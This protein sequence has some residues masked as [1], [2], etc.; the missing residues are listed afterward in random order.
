MQKFSIKDLEN[1]TGIKAHTI[2]AWE[3]RYQLL[4]PQRTATNIRYYTD[5]DLKLLLNVNL[6]NQ[7]GVKISKIAGMTEQ[8]IEKLIAEKTENK[9]ENAH[10]LNMLKLSMLNYDET[11]FREITKQF[12]KE[13][14]VFEMF[15][16]LY[17]PFMNQVG[18]LWLTSAICPAQ[19]HFVSNLIRQKL[20]SLI[21]ENFQEPTGDERLFVLY[22]PEKEIHEISLTLA[23]YL[24]RDRGH[25]SIFLGQSVP[26]EDLSAVEKKFNSVEFVTICTTHPSAGKVES[27]IDK[28]VEEFK[29]KN[30]NF[31]L[32]GP[33]FSKFEGQGPEW[34][35]IYKNA[36]ELVG[37]LLD[38]APVSHS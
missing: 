38:L 34:L 8:E 18:V 23:H 25:R 24:L 33:V 5:A 13:H 21:E 29:N 31:H 7:R 1:F 22:L 28:I 30:V 11:L 32:T 14:T 6:L 35:N 15:H 4:N 36:Y 3:Q 10:F 9:G 16:Q 37:S 17:L 20:F 27:Y 26:F 12:L 2:R 19:E